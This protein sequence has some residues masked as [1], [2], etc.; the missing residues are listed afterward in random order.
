MTLLW[1][2]YTSED[3]VDRALIDDAMQ[4]DVGEE[5]RFS[6]LWRPDRIDSIIHSMHSLFYILLK[7][8]WHPDVEGTEET[9]ADVTQ[10]HMPLLRIE[11]TV[12]AGAPLII[13]SEDEDSDDEDEDK[14]VV[15]DKDDDDGPGHLDD[16]EGGA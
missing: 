6:V 1:S 11:P 12:E 16:D 10:P 14:D 3:G 9:P 8:H 15:E 7:S 2:Q 5:M 4:L 13:E